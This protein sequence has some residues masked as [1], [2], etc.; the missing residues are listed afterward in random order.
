MDIQILWNMTRKNRLVKPPLRMCPEL[1]NALTVFGVPK[2]NH[3]VSFEY[4]LSQD[5]DQDQ[6]PGIPDE[7]LILTRATQGYEL[8]LTIL[9]VRW[10]NLRFS[11]NWTLISS[12]RSCS[13]FSGRHQRGWF[14]T[15]VSFGKCAWS[16]APDANAFAVLNYLKS[17]FTRLYTSVMLLRESM[18][19]ESSS[20]WEWWC[21]V[22]EWIRAFTGNG[23]AQERQ[24]GQIIC[25]RL[26]LERSHWTVMTDLDGLVQSEERPNR[27][28]KNGSEQSMEFLARASTRALADSLLIWV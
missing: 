19:P 11:L 22:S 10:E 25:I 26:L 12:C 3:L 6:D 23:A 24:P 15:R 14:G 8:K 4:R 1:R 27:G 13:S 7:Q 16:C 20:R 9:L 5:Q 18:L 21:V 28:G 2:K 17:A